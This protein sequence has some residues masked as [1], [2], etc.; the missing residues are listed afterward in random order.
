MTCKKVYFKL[1]VSIK[2]YYYYYYDFRVKYF[3][4][5]DFSM[6]FYSEL[7]KQAA[8]YFLFRKYRCNSLNATKDHTFFLFIE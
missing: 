6:F 8:M 3:D 7:K 5:R 1:K 4:L 2:I